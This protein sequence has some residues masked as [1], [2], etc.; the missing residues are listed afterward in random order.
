[1]FNPKTDNGVLDPVTIPSL[2]GARLL[3]PYGH[4][5]RTGSLRDF[6]RNV[7]V[8]NEFWRGPE[9]SSQI[10]DAIVAYIEDID[11]LPNPGVSTN[12]DRRPD[13]KRKP[14]AT[15]RRGAFPQALPA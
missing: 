12:K 13:A 14:I 4:D 9:P 3:A 1:M 7:I 8:S 5:G 11:F 10:L 6:V 15:A 2:R